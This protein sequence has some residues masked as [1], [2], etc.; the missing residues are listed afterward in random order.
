MYCR[1]CKTDQEKGNV[2]FI[3]GQKQFFCSR[4]CDRI[5][6]ATVEQKERIKREHGKAYFCSENSL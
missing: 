1:F 6:K 4:C 3:A 2:I 5:Q